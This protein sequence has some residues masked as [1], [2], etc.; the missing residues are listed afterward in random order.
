MAS[1]R[2]PQDTFRPISTLAVQI[3]ARL[4]ARKAVTEQ[5]RSEGERV[6]LALD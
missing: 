1:N 6:M 4:A 3:L 5:L 2:L